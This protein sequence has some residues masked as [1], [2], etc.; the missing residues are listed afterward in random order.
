MK[1]SVAPDN[2]TEQA[3]PDEIEHDANGLVKMPRDRFFNPWRIAAGDNLKAVVNEAVGMVTNYEGFFEQRKRSRKPADK[4]VFE[5]IIEAVICDMMVAHLSGDKR[6]SAVS[7]SHQ[8]LGRRSRYR[9]NVFSKSLPAILERMAAPEM[10]FI[11]IQKGFKQN[12]GNRGQRTLIWPGERIGWRIDEHHI[13]LDDITSQKA[14]E[15]IVLKGHK[16]GF[17]DEGIYEEYD[18]IPTTTRMR[19]ELAE[20]NDWLTEASITLDRPSLIVDRDIQLN[21]RRLRRI[22]TR[23]SF[24]NGGRLFGGFWQPM[25]KQERLQAIKI[26][27]EPVVGLDFGQ[28]APR[29]IYGLAKAKPKQDDLYDIEGM[30]PNYRAGIKLLLNAMLFS[31]MPLKR[32]P[33]GSKDLLPKWPIDQLVGSIVQSHTPIAQYFHTGIGHQV[34]FI[35]SEIMMLVLLDLM[36]KGV[37]CLPIHDGVIIPQSAHELARQVMEDKSEEVCGI[38]IPVSTER[39]LRLDEVA[40]G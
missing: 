25:A 7:L 15:T 3:G 6:G 18:D 22:F 26:N 4:K 21:D 39:D 24:E 33:Q 16:Q 32:K 10:A 30:H 28:T 14:E 38:R 8:V 11:V 2:A 20:V 37:V 34:Q 19:N 12:F 17:W 9:P 5:E 27:G 23:S 31:E 40:A 36:S 29:I 35:E 1:T 13:E